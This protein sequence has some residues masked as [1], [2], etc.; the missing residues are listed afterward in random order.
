MR[1]KEKTN[2]SLKSLKGR[3]VESKMVALVNSFENLW[4]HFDSV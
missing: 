1:A 2:S 3:E 4:I